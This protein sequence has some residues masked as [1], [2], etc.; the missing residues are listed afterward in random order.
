MPDARF[1]PQ[2]QRKNS[3]GKFKLNEKSYAGCE[4]HTA[5]AEKFF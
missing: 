4:V 2:R 1:T 3:F 5:E